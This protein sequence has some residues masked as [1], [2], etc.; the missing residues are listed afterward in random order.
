MAYA[1]DTRNRMTK[2][3]HKDGQSVVDGFT[4]ALDPQDEITRVTDQDSAYWDYGYDTR[5]RLQRIGRDNGMDRMN[6]ETADGKVA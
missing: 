1:Y 3:E 6:L 5:H 2:I 4:Y